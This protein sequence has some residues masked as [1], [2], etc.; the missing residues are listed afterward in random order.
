M[1]T[2]EVT[3]NLMGKLVS[4]KV[5]KEG[6]ERGKIRGNNEGEGGR[7]KGKGKGGK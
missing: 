5:G 6:E 4:V 7:G 1:N 3:R 2:R